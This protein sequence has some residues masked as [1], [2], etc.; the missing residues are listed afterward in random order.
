MRDIALA[1]VT[2]FTLYLT[3]FTLKLKDF[4]LK[5]VSHAIFFRAQRKGNHAIYGVCYC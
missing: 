3:L 5:N 2:T 4:V 1:I